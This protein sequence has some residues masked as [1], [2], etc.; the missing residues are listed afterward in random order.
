MGARRSEIQRSRRLMRRL[1]S[2]KTCPPGGYKDE[3]EG[4][5]C[6]EY[7][8]EHPEEESMGNTYSKS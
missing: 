3:E 1:T 7:A 6:P 8:L 5:P 2:G 4:Q